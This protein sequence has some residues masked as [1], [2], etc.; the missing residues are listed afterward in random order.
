V[1]HSG[2]LQVQGLRHGAVAGV[3]R[4][5]DRPGCPVS[6]GRPEPARDYPALERPAGPGPIEF[7]LRTP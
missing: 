3:L 5:S 2:A 6:S 7:S 1:T 4:T